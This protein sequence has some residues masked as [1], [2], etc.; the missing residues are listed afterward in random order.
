[1]RVCVCY[2]FYVYILYIFIT[3]IIYN[4]PFH[5]ATTAQSQCFMVIGKNGGLSTLY[6]SC[7]FAFLQKVEKTFS[8]TWLFPLHRWDNRI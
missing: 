6:Y 1:M 3:C 8:S 2:M 7:T 5:R 4:S